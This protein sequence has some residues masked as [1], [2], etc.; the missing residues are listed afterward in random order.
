MNVASVGYATYKVISRYD[1]KNN[2][3][4][5][6]IN[7]SRKSLFDILPASKEKHS[8]IF[9]GASIIQYGEWREL[10][11]QPHIINRGIAGD[12]T[13]DI[14]E[15]LAEVI[16]R[17]PKQLF[18]M[19]GLND[20]MKDQLPIV[21]A[22]QMTKILEQCRNESPVTSV[23]VLSILPIAKQIKNSSQLNKIIEKNKHSLSKNIPTA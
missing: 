16:T 14:R 17:K 5:R 9:L 13:R 23:Y 15:R 2:T 3:A 18:I 22:E 12:T 20:I 4:A 7:L 1:N 8:I 11:Q 6:W 21:I 10:L 19:A